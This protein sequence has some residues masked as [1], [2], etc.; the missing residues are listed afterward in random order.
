[1]D[2][3]DENIQYTSVAAAIR[4]LHHQGW[5]ASGKTLYRHI[6]QSKIN[7]KPW[8]AADLDKYAAEYLRPIVREQPK[9]K[10]ISGAAAELIQARREKLRIET[11]LKEYEL[12]LKK[13]NLIEVTEHTRLVCAKLY[14]IR[15][16]SF[17]WIREYAVEIISACKGDQG[18]SADVVEIYQKSIEKY[19]ARMDTDAEFPIL[20]PADQQPTIL[21]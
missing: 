16:F 15:D 6:S 2:E 1:M 5:R 8:S 11:E 10:K 3:I 14:L 4:Y 20:Q 17:N 12:E 21:D 18:R 7:S 13:G 19:L 9:G